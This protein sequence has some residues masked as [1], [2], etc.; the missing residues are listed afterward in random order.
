MQ[1]RG[2]GGQ[3]PGAHGHE[4][5]MNDI[6]SQHFRSSLAGFSQISRRFIVIFRG[7]GRV[8]LYIL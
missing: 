6:L 2:V 5:P 7:F 4:G 8:K 1:G 3:K